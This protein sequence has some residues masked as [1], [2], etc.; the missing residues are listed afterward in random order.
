M[1]PHNAKVFFNFIKQGLIRVNCRDGI[2]RYKNRVLS[3][4]SSG[5]SIVFNMTFQGK[6]YKTGLEKI[7]WMAKHGI[8]NSNEFI[9]FKNGIKSDCRIENLELFINTF[10]HTSKFR[11][12]DNETVIKIRK[13]FKLGCKI[14][15]I[16]KYYN[17]YERTIYDIIYNVTY[18]DITDIVKNDIILVNNNSNSKLSDEKVSLIKECWISHKN[19]TETAAIVGCSFK[20]AKKYI[21][22]FNNKRISEFKI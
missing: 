9:G 13:M 7:V 8:L 5:Q 12:L 19:I 18:T 10:G 20:T 4:N 3:S 11:T 1:K 16:A 17:T 22:Y 14:V 6:C 21:N 15:D 2:V